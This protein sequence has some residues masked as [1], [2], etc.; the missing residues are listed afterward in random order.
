MADDPQRLRVKRRS[1]KGSITK[2]LTKVDSAL[3][4]ELNTINST[5]VDESQRLAFNTV[6]GQLKT[7]RDLIIKLDGDISDTIKSDEELET[8]LN[9]ADDYLMNLEEKI[10]ILEEYV[11]KA[12]QPPVMPR[13]DVPLLT[14]HP[15]SNT[16]MVA[17]SMQETEVVKKSAHKGTDSTA[18]DLS[19]PVSADN[20]N[21]SINTSH[22]TQSHMRLP[23]L[24]LPIFNGNRQTFW[25]SFVAAIDESWIIA[26]TK[27]QL[28][29]CTAGRRCCSSHQWFSFDR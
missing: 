10:A 4:C 17:H 12:S 13:Q 27:I 2:L 19:Q 21:L 28:P 23:K 22:T 1:C 5:T 7:K 9:D 25:D 15:P 29:E 8:E 24:T 20:V 3:S 18:K 16:E 26:S 14:P 6:L 11:K